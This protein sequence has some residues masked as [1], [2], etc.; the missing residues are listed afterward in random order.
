MDK[1]PFDSNVFSMILKA[2]VDSCS[3]GI[4]NLKPSA[5]SLLG[6]L[7]I[8]DFLLIVLLHFGE[9]D[10]IKLLIKK[11]L[12]YGFFFLIVDRFSQIVNGLIYGFIWIGLVAG[13]KDPQGFTASFREI[14]PTAI[15]KVG[16]NISGAIFNPILDALEVAPGAGLIYMLKALIS[17]IIILSFIT[18]AI[19]IFVTIIEFYVVTALTIILIPFGANKHT[20]FIGEKAMGLT[21]SFGVKLMVLTFISIL[22]QKIA[23]S[24]DLQA[25]VLFDQ[26]GFNTAIYAMGA[27]LALAVLAW[28]APNLAAGLMAGSPTLTAGNAISP[29]ITA[30]QTAID[31]YKRISSNGSGAGAVATAGNTSSTASEAST[32]LSTASKSSVANYTSGSDYEE[33]QKNNPLT[34]ERMLSMYE[35]RLKNQDNST[36]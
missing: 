24:F 35:D 30:T 31:L 14:N 5:L 18:I 9:T 2:F 27:S 29:L 25:G 36:K 28:Q 8:I 21:I 12:T 15:V 20:A 3:S 16:L 11:T 33:F 10:Y 7:A 13:G 22:I 34:S 32:A 4:S 1:I 19:Q 17:L 23:P 6:L 26:N